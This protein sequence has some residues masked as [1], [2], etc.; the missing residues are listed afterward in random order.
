MDENQLKRRA[1][2]T[3]KLIWLALLSS[4]LLYILVAYIVTKDKAITQNDYSFVLYVFI[5]ISVAEIALIFIIRSIFETRIRKTDGVKARQLSFTKDIVSWALSES[6]ALYGFALTIMTNC[7]SYII[8]FS[9]PTIAL[10]L[11]LF[12]RIEK[13]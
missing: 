10:Y 12:P 5:G 4:I 7:M 11:V 2:L 8:Y 3:V 9:I 6:I 13:S 1:A